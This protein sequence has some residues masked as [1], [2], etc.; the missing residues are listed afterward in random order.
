MLPLRVDNAY[1]MYTH[2]A[3]QVY[4]IG[5]KFHTF[6]V[7]T[8]HT[9]HSTRTTDHGSVVQLRTRA[10]PHMWGIFKLLAIETYKMISP[11]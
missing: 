1:F 7:R 10:K 5:K 6:H 4:I 2:I 8:D 9:N 3:L 11:L